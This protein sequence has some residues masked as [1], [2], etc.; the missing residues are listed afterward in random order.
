MG[1]NVRDILQRRAL[2]AMKPKPL[3]RRQISQK[4]VHGEIA[5]G[6]GLRA[7]IVDDEPA[8]THLVERF[9]STGGWECT[10]VN[11]S[12]TVEAHLCGK[13]FDFVIC[14]LRMPGENGLEVLAL[15]RKKRPQLAAR[16]L[17]MTGDLAGAEEQ[18]TVELAGV[19]ILRKPFTLAQ[20]AGA[21]R[22]VVPLAR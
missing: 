9:L 21:L 22:R 13:S 5:D 8:I 3:S 7:L 4:P 17:L 2:T 6:T 19:P 18:E 1:A 15:L 16:F 12:R 20:L 14:D 11:D 10:V